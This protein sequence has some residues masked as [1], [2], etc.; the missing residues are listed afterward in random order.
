CGF[1]REAF[2]PCYGLAEAT[3][4]VSGTSQPAINGS[5][6]GCGGLKYDPEV[7]IVNPETFVKCTTGEVG[8]IWISGPSVAAGYWNHPEE[9]ASVFHARLAGS[10]SGPYLRSGDLGFVAGSELFVTGRIKDLIII[11]GRNLYPHEI[12]RTVEQSHPSL[13][14]GCGA[15]FSIEDEG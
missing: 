2:Y 12:E 8:E 3:L 9:T 15:A 4:F 13:K 14:P 5:V 6:V 11:R 1:R 10:D 7:V